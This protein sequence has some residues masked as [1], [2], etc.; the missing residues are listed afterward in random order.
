VPA[1]LTNLRWVKFAV[2]AIILVA[3]SVMARVAQNAPVA[4]CSDVDG[5]GV[6][7]VADNCVNTPN[8]DQHD[9]DGDGYGDACDADYNNDGVVGIADFNLLRS[10]FGKNSTSP[11]FNPVVDTDDDGA[12]GLP[13][14]NLLRSQFGKPPGPSN[15]LGPPTVLLTQP[16]HG[17][18]IFAGDSPTCQ[19][20]VQ[21][22]V[23]NVAPVV[24]SLLVNGTPVNGAEVTSDGQF[25]TT[26]TEPPI[27][28]P[29]LAEATRDEFNGGPPDAGS[30][31]TVTRVQNVAI[32]GDSILENT[33]ALSSVGVRLNNS[34]FQKL[35]PLINSEVNSLIPTVEQ[36]IAKSFPIPVNQCEGS[37]LYGVCIGVE[38]NQISL[39]TFTVGSVSLGLG[40]TTNAIDVNG[41]IVSPDINVTISTSLGSCQADAHA[42]SVD[43][44]A[45]LGLAPG[46]P[47]SELAATLVTPA[48]LTLNNLNLS[49]SNCDGIIAVFAGLFDLVKGSINFDSLATPPLQNALNS[50]LPSLLNSALSGVMIPGQVGIGGGLNLEGLFSSVSEDT[51][52]VTFDLDGNVTP[53][54]PGPLPLPASY[55]TF[56]QFPGFGATEPGGK[57]YDVALT[58]SENLL[59]KLLRSD[60][61][62]GNF[63]DDL[64]TLPGTNPPQVISTTALGLLIPG[65]F[66]VPAENLKLH[67]QSTLAPVLTVGSSS[68][69]PP[70]NAHV[71]VAGVDVTVVGLNSGKTFLTAR[72]NGRFEIVPG[73]MGNSINFTLT[74]VDS[75][76]LVLISS[77]VGATDAQIALLN[78]VLGAQL[79]QAKI[80]QTLDSVQLPSFPGL[81]TT[82]VSVAQDAGFITLFVQ[83][84]PM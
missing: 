59:N 53:T 51:V 44:A 20:P 25:Q 37:E 12:I 34:G 50:N 28:A 46:N 78:T 21:G 26:L 15:A 8:P 74:G 42:D 45:A 75:A 10:Q 38:I 1:Y 79:S 35:T 19:I 82:P 22:S 3:V 81:T 71:D 57:A 68:A 23:P 83:L 14:F 70:T 5:D 73:I 36:D 67:L 69:N 55:V 17:A 33:L 64:T 61:E 77:T 72:L 24:L 84:I 18:F 40:S 76:N 80:S 43:V 48:T 11:G 29:V 41:A 63:N 49:L 27:F 30:S 16:A 39:N 13:E 9:T 4:P 6:C 62:E 7:D 31:G 47:R 60:A 66:A 2:L 52:G 58:L 65:F 54:T 32:C 56:T